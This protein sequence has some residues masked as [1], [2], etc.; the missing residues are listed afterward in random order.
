M[1]EPPISYKQLLNALY[2][3]YFIAASRE[4]ALLEFKPQSTTKEKLCYSIHR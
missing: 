1:K 2:K 4:Y 3:K